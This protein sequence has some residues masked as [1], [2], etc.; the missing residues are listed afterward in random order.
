MSKIKCTRNLI[1]HN[2]WREII[3]QEFS[4]LCF[5]YDEKSENLILDIKD[6]K[7]IKVPFQINEFFLVG[8]NKENMLKKSLAK[9][10][11]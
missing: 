2:N 8:E 6:D 3:S 11:P 7:V 4:F 9:K 1:I 10:N 5:K